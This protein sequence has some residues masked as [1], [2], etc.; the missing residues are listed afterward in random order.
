MPQ[1]SSNGAPGTDVD[2]P[3]AGE[4][5][6]LRL[7]EGT[8]AY[9]TKVLGRGSSQRALRLAEGKSIRQDKLDEVLG[10]VAAAPKR[11]M[12]SRQEERAIR[13]AEGTISDEHKADIADGRAVK[14]L[15]DRHQGRASEQRMTARRAV[16]K[17]H[18]QFESIA[19][20]LAE[21]KLTSGQRESIA[22]GSAV[23]ALVQKRAGRGHITEAVRMAEGKLSESERRAIAGGHAAPKYLRDA[24]GGKRQSEAERLAEG[25]LSN[26]ERL[27]IAGGRAAPTFEYGG[28]SHEAE[29]E[30]LAEGKLT[31]LQRL[32]EDGGRAA[33]SFVTSSTSLAHES[34]AV[35][36]AEGRLSES[37]RLAIAGGGA[38]AKYVVGGGEHEDEAVRL[39]EGKVT[40]REAL[41][42]AGGRAA[43][44]AVQLHDARRESVAVRLAEGKFTGE[45]RLEMAG[46]RAAPD[47]I[48]AEGRGEDEAVRLAEGHDSQQAEG[49]RRNSEASWSSAGS[50]EEA[51]RL[52]HGSDE[53]SGEEVGRDGDEGREGRQE[54][55]GRAWSSREHGDEEGR[56]ERQVKLSEL[57][58]E[59]RSRRV[60]RLLG[61]ATKIARNAF[62]STRT[63][64]LSQV[65]SQ[66]QAKVGASALSKRK[67]DALVD[68]VDGQTSGE[69]QNPGVAASQWRGMADKVLGPRK[70]GGVSL[71]DDMGGINTVAQ[72]AQ[73]SLGDVSVPADKAVRR[74]WGGL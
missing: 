1:L 43:S 45:E 54:T 67:V 4:S 7:A 35:R 60:E 30:R 26:Q 31:R 63:E 70:A 8:A 19:M 72:G 9:D 37:E 47:S 65:D 25:K 71:A 49:S 53:S 20:R 29:A 42:R 15:I 68:R 14:A 64:E 12:E 13:L 18:P 61:M 57:S 21:G 56:N 55:R 24:Q 46:G 73:A 58:D 66:P 27:A 51:L 44:R 50:S 59:E 3:L 69:I 23:S 10:S 11:A 34:E 6:A 74:G 32:S 39:A 40:P 28:P 16:G 22:R 38:A 41:M 52:S 33:P 62:K 36:L 2:S 5:H 17:Q 48:Q